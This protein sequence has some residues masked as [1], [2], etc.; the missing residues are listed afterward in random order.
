MRS[1]ASSVSANVNKAVVFL[2]VAACKAP[3]P[4]TVSVAPPPQ[5]S[6]A[7][8]IEAPAGRCRAAFHRDADAAM[9]A[10]GFEL[11]WR[12]ADPGSG[13][14]D[15]S[16]KA[17]FVALVHGSDVLWEFDLLG[18]PDAKGYGWSGD[19]KLL[20]ARTTTV[21]GPSI[22][23]VRWEQRTGGWSTGAGGDTGIRVVMSAVCT[24]ETPKCPFVQETERE[25]AVM[26]AVGRHVDGEA[27]KLDVG[28][29][30][31]VTATRT[32]HFSDDESARRPVRVK[33]F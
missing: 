10:A 11:C 32:K 2:F 9:K 29:D 6:P 20:G 15:G 26:D 27:W 28:A 21:A 22:I 8:P 5:A 3:A 31:F 25:M 17:G 19:A 7:A 23:T 18:G 12:E 13:N 1:P 33:I 16:G 14:A 4:V 30:G 24:T